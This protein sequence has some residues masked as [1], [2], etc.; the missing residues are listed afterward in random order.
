MVTSRAV[1]GSS[2]MSRR[3][4]NGERHGDHHPLEH[5]PGQLVGEG[6]LH[7]LRVGQPDLAEHLPAAGPGR[8][9]WTPWA[10]RV[11]TIWVRTRSSGLSEVI[12]SW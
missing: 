12:G 4:R 7:P 2:A 5:P 6:A 11:S 8:A 10:R 3:G 9:R 1:V